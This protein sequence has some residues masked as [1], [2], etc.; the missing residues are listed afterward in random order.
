VPTADLHQ[1]SHILGHAIDAAE[2]AGF[3]HRHPQIGEP[4]RFS[5]RLTEQ[6]TEL[7]LEHAAGAIGSSLKALAIDG[8]STLDSS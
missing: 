5:L 4:R 8:D 3:S 2:I 1:L 6:P 7:G